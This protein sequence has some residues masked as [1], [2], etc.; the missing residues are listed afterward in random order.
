VPHRDRL[1]RVQQ[2]CLLDFAGFAGGERNG[3]EF[4]EPP[5]ADRIISRGEAMRQGVGAIVGLRGFPWHGTHET[6]SYRE[7]GVFRGTGT[8]R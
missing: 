7:I 4:A 5:H 1:I 3:S 2:Q 6:R 8:S